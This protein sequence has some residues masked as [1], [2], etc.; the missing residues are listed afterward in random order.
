MRRAVVMATAIALFLRA[1]P[2]PLAGQATRPAAPTRRDAAPVRLVVLLVLDQFRPDYF[3]RWTPQLNGGLARLL[4][5]GVFYPR[6]EQ[7]RALT[8][9]APGHSTLLSGRSPASTGILSDGVGVGDPLSPLIGTTGNGASPRRFIGST[10]YDWMLAA[11]SGVRELSVSLKDRSAILPI[12][13]A[14]V[15]VYWYAGGHYTTSKYYADS[16]PT[17]LVVWNAKDPVGKL[18]GTSWTLSHPAATYAEPDDRVFENGGNDRTFPHILPTDWTQATRA[19]EDFS[20]TDSLTLDVALHGFRALGLGQ[21]GRP[22]LL[23]ISLSATDYIGHKWGTGSREIHDHVLNLDRWLG[24][25]LDSLAKLVPPDQTLMVV[26]ADH[27][28]QDFPEATNGSRITLAP[29]VRALNRWARERWHLDLGAAQVDGLLYGDFRAL[30]ARG[31]DVDS[32][33]NAVATQLR[34]LPGVTTVYTPRS[35]AGARRNNLDAMRW[36]RA[37]PAS[38][39]WLVA[40]SVREHVLVGYAANSTG[41]GTTNAADVQVPIVFWM[42]GLPAGRNARVIRTIDIAPTLAAW[43]GVRPT[44]AVEGSPIKEII[45]YRR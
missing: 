38:V 19:I 27:G 12:G 8:E 10:L 36:R 43:L 14:R 45:R 33:A 23:S 44:E 37:I 4:E 20:I 41:H 5:H 32:L 34:A 29:Q 31:V 9:T 11:D 17:W 25:F 13:R 22:D 42:P 18:K 28:G 6:G 21:R 39:S 24:A 2:V 30:Q 3:D 35:L 7:D 26:T 16:L 15:P 40:T 1:A